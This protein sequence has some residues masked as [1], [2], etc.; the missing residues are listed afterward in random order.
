MGDCSAVV[1]SRHASPET[2]IV[3]L[4]DFLK[5]I[6]KFPVS[7]GTSVG[8]EIKFFKLPKVRDFL[9]ILSLFDRQL[10][11]TFF[12]QNTDSVKMRSV[13]DLFGNQIWRFEKF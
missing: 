6:Q 8:I 3:E 10:K 9:I 2:L 5:E 12:P 4:N 1:R 11:K 13:K 7:C